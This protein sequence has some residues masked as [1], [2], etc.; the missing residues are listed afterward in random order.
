MGTG[1]TDDSSVLSVEPIYEFCIVR[2]LKSVEEFQATSFLLTEMPNHASHTIVVGEARTADW[3]GSVQPRR[4][5]PTV[6]ALSVRLQRVDAGK[7]VL[8]LRTHL[9][10]DHRS[11]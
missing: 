1:S 10:F 3:T 11:Q 4:M 5:P 9:P 6:L 2:L 7:A 8:A